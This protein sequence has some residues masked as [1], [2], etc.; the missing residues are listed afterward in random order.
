MNKKKN[1]NRKNDLAKKNAIESLRF[2]THFGLK[3]MGCE[4]GNIFQRL[5][6]TELSFIS[7]LDLTQDILDIKK[8]IDGVR[9]NL[10]VNPTPEKGDFCTSITAIALKI[11]TISN[12]DEML[13]PVSWEE[14]MKKKILAIYFPENDRNAVVDWAKSNG[15]N[16]ST[17]L[18]CPIVK[19]SKLYIKIGRTRA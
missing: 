7:E 10:Q 17:Y 16:T 9:A 14:Q 4:D 15:Y 18:G 2:Q 12:L 5:A 1:Q 3:Q 19:F 13:M 8:M 6:E 11:A